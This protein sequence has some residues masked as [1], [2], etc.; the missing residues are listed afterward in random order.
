M[1]NSKFSSLARPIQPMPD[2]IKDALI[3]NH[4][5]DAY[6]NRPPYQ[7]ND[8]LGWINRV[9]TA[10]LLTV[11]SVPLALPFPTELCEKAK[12]VKPINITAKTDTLFLKFMVSSF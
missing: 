12:Q 7:Q 4:L 6:K 10:N 9:P 5:L 11:K 8:Y 1:T 3:D 2:F